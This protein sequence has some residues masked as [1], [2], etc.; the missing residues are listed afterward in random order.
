MLSR[1]SKLAISSVAVAAFSASTGAYAIAADTPP[2]L[3]GDSDLP[4]AVEDGAYPNAAQIL[5]DKGIKLLRGDGNITLAECHETAKQIRVLTVADAA[6]NRAGTYCFESRGS[7]GLLTLELPRVFAIDAADQPLSAKLTADGQ[8]KTVTIA[9]DG[10]ASVGEG[11]V[12]GARSTLLEIRATGSE[13]TTTPS[14][15]SGDT[16]LAFS[17]KLKIGDTKACSAALVDPRWVIT[18]KS[19]FADN[20]AAS[21]T[22]AAGAP[23]EKTTVVLGKPHLDL[24]GGHTSEIVQLVPHPDR[25]LVMGR[26]DKPVSDIAP[27]AI[28]SAAPTTDQQLTVVGFGRTKTGWAPTMRHDAVFTA[29]AIK[30]TGFDLAA[31]TPAE[32]TV[33]SGDAGGPAMR[34]ESATKYTLFGVTSRSWQGKCLG[35]AEVRTGAF[36]TRVDNVRDW[37][38]RVRDLSPGWRTQALVQSGNSLYQGVRLADGSWTD[39]VDVQTKAGSIGGIRSSSAAGRNGDTHLLA[40]S[41]SGGL[42]HTV[43]KQDGTWDGFGDVFSAANTLG[44][45]TQVSVTNI[46][47]D[48]HV[49]AVADGK[50][51]HTIRTASGNWAPF[52]NISAGVAN[53]TTAATANVRGEL[54]VAAVSGGKAYHTIRQTNGNWHGWGNIAQVAGNTGPITSI[55]ITGAGDETHFVIAT[56]NGTRQYHA[57]RNFNGSWNAFAELKDILGTVTAKSVSAATVNG[58]V[59]VSVTTGDGKLLHTIR[60]TDRTWSATTAVGTQGLPAAPGHL[61]TTATWNG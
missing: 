38:Q 1:A 9:K 23:K 4:F 27:V 2:T 49:V 26:L 54:Q 11:M 24:S 32:A 52:G 53:V 34:Q 21:N 8:S 25:D 61:A 18:A 33:C 35:S 17:G 42:F 40:V 59:Q 5:T 56:D 36:A 13:I 12:G 60:R 3:P 50:A 47:N 16:S 39:F 58:E 48:L 7:T 28:S 19:C 57:I 37:V 20:P 43:R 45:L 31:K 29:G 30:A 41:N 22:V 55:S 51:F 15:P 6:A 10:Y 44:N 46:G 14:V